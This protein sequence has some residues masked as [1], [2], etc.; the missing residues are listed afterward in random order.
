MLHED[1]HQTSVPALIA[2][3]F[4]STWYI[5]CGQC[6]SRFDRQREPNSDRK[7]LEPQLRVTDRTTGMNVINYF[8]LDIFQR[9]QRWRTLEDVNDS[10]ISGSRPWR[11]ATEKV[12]PNTRPVV[13][14]WHTKMVAQTPHDTP[15]ATRQPRALSPDYQRRGLR[16]ADLP[17]RKPQTT[18]LLLVRHPD[19]VTPVIAA[20]IEGR[21]APQCSSCSARR[22]QVCRSPPHEPP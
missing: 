17:P 20:Q 8:S 7:N 21:T 5:S 1:C 10:S 4:Y 14:A 2:V 18:R 9:P 11:K 22:F 12:S 3:S 19:F 6:Y 15:T 13:S 16:Q